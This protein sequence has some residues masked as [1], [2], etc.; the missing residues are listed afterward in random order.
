LTH[1]LYSL[2][3]KIHKKRHA[4]KN[5]I[6]IIIIII[7]IIFSFMQGIHTRIPE[8]KHVPREYIAAAILSFIIIIISLF[9]LDKFHQDCNC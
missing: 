6:I 9:N 3:Q 2:G 1:L 4:N 8:T 7:I 5:S